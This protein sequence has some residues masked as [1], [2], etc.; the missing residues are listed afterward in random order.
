[1]PG[2][3]NGVI[4]MYSLQRHDTP[5]GELRYIP[6]SMYVGVIASSGRVAVT[7]ASR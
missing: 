3:D 5:L 2:S 1:M 4:E 7:V 6:T